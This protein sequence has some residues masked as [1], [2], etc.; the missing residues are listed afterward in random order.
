LLIGFVIAAPKGIVD[1]LEGPADGPFA[2]PLGRAPLLLRL[3]L[4]GLVI[5]LGYVA[6]V[7]FPVLYVYGLIVLAIVGFVAFLAILASA[8]QRLRDM[9]QSG[10]WAL[11]MFVPP[12]NAALLVVLLIVPSRANKNFA[13]AASAS[14]L[15]SAG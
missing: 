3:V 8:S 10:W 6:I 7:V 15:Q 9:G 12:L 2:A 11:L 1:L 4:A 5:G 13:A 14:S